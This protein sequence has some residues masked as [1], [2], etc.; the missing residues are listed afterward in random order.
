MYVVY[1]MENIDQVK[2]ELKEELRTEMRQ[3]RDQLLHLPLKKR[4]P[5]KQ[6]A[7]EAEEI[8]KSKE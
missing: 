6:T 7:R 8:T 4:P 2:K 1:K 3:L 5:E